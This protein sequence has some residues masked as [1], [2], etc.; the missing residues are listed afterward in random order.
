MNK[1]FISFTRHS[2]FRISLAVC[3]LGLLM[4]GSVAIEKNMPSKV[5]AADNSKLC[6]RSVSVSKGDT[7]WSVAR[8]H[9]SQE[10]GSISNYMKEIK[11]CNDLTSE[12]ITAGSCLVVPIYLPLDSISVNTAIESANQY[13]EY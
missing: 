11:R 4:R 8:E 7:L 3:I 5:T 1:N 12:K 13:N 9:Y 10:W 6:Y 2:V